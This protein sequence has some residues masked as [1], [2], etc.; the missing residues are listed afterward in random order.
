MC[1]SAIALSLNI[2]MSITSLY[3]QRLLTVIAATSIALACGTNVR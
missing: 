1:Q 3:V 2:A